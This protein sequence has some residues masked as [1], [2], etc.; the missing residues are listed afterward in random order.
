MTFDRFAVVLQSG[1]CTTSNIEKSDNKAIY[2]NTFKDNKGS[3]LS[4]NIQYSVEG[5][6]LSWS[7][8][9]SDANELVGTGV[10]VSECN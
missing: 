5:E 8:K 4:G 6:K 2:D 3:E 7:I 10:Y 9:L 1:N